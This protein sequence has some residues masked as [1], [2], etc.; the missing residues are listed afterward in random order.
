M[1]GTRLLSWGAALTSDGD[2]AG[3]SRRFANHPDCSRPAVSLG[4]AGGAWAYLLSAVLTSDGDKAGATGV[5]QTVPIAAGLDG[6]AR[7]D[8]ARCGEQSGFGQF[9]ALG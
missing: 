1:G 3:A 9:G 5:L 8:S 4:T 6:L 7:G 2:R